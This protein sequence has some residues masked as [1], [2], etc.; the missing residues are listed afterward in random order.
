[1]KK[2]IYFLLVSY[3]PAFSFAQQN[4]SPQQMEVMMKM[5]SLR[6]ALLNKDSSTLSNLLSDD[7]TYGHSTG[8]IQTKA[9]LIRAVISGE[10]TYKI[11]EPANINI[12]IYDNTGVVT[13]KS[14]VNIIYQGNP[15]DLTMNV[16]LVWVKFKDQWRLVARQAVKL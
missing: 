16:L 4:T 14:K 7:V 10:Q 8:L 9:E 5:S 6:S 13:M 15:L 11:I 2:L 3:M 12:R 1:M